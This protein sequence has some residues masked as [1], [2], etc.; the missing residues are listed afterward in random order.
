MAGRPKLP[1]KV[2]IKFV[3]KLGSFFPYQYPIPIVKKTGKSTSKSLIN[4]SILGSKE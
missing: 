1:A 4:R 2:V 3:L